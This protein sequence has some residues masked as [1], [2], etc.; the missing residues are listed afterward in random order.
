MHTYKLSGL[1]L[2]ILGTAGGLIHSPAFLGS[3]TIAELLNWLVTLLYSLIHG[4]L[5]ESDLALLLKVLLADLLLGGA[6]LCDISVVA[7]LH[8]LVGAL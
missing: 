1:F 3:L 6:E 5:L 2:H 4:L 7:L 8:Q